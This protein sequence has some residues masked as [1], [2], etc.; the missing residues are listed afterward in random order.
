MVTFKHFIESFSSGC[1]H[2]DILELIK[3]FKDNIKNK[4]LSYDDTYLPLQ[5]IIN[6]LEEHKIDD[7]DLEKLSYWV[8]K[9]DITQ[10]L[11]D[12]KVNSILSLLDNYEKASAHHGVPSFKVPYD[13]KKRSFLVVLIK[14]LYPNYVIQ[15]EIDGD[16]YE[17]YRKYGDSVDVGMK[18]PFSDHV[19]ND[20]FFMKKSLGDYVKESGTDDY[21]HFFEMD[22]DL[23]DIEVY[24]H[25]KDRTVNSILL[26]YNKLKNGLTV[27]SFTNEFFD[28]IFELVHNRISMNTFVIINDTGE[29]N[30]R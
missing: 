30:V 27:D 3:K 18:L 29:Q 8:N 28:D 17:L 4:S 21:S 19:K 14:K 26:P 11:T 9:P 25:H 23:F 24:F 22:S 6:C 13:F 15:P 12:Q 10:F 5:I 20:A 2:S 1:S 7:K 16:F